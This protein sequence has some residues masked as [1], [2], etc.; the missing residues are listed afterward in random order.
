MF[1]DLYNKRMELTSESTKRFIRFANIP[2]SLIGLVF[3]VL[4][5]VIF[6]K[7]RFK[8]HKIAFY[9]RINALNHSFILVLFIIGYVLVLHNIEI[10][11]FSNLTCKT[12]LF[13][14]CSALQ[15][16]SWLELL[17]TFDRNN[18]MRCRKMMRIRSKKTILKLVACLLLAILLFN[19]PNLAFS[20]TDVDSIRNMT[21]VFD[22]MPLNQTFMVKVCF[23]EPIVILLRDVISELLRL[24]IPFVLM[25]FLNITL[26][27][28]LK[29]STN[30]EI[31]SSLMLN[32]KNEKKRFFKKEIYYGF[33]IFVLNILFF[34]T[35]I[36]IAIFVIIRSIDQYVFQQ[37]VTPQ[38]IDNSYFMFLITIFIGSFYYSMAF[39]THLVFNKHFY[40]EFIEIVTGWLFWTNKQARLSYDA[41]NVVENLTQ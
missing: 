15:F 29:M 34:L 1:L 21:T 10:T 8:N 4:V 12:Y 37:S 35:H 17:I 38:S 33:T 5:I 19:T 25:V 39:L 2:M 18:S 6:S 30:S 36:P 31:G 11:I 23:S 3:N 20:L 32:N 7:K 26:F 22:S 28:D 27:R 14:F 9:S 24:Y 13:I 41:N 40:T 16:S